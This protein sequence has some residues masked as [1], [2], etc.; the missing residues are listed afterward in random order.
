MTHLNL[1]ELINFLETLNP[2]QVVKNGFGKAGSY[3]GF[4][5]QIAFEPAEGVTVESMLQNA[6]AAVGET[7]YGWHGGR[8]RMTKKTLVNIALPGRCHVPMR[9]R[10]LDEITYERLQKDF[11]VEL[12]TVVKK[13]VKKNKKNNTI[14]TSVHSIILEIKETVEKRNKSGETTEIRNMLDY[15]YLQLEKDIEHS[16]E[17]GKW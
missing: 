14:P 13:T 7:F 15:L 2:K 3:R 10:S 6:K 4:Y 9:G 16:I 12:E 11:S 8:Y 1:G 17:E 5:D